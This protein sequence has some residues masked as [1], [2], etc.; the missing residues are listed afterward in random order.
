M[1]GKAPSWL[2]LQ[3]SFTPPLRGSSSVLQLLWAQI[4]PTSTPFML[5]IVACR[6]VSDRQTWPSSVVSAGF[7]SGRV[8]GLSSSF[9]EASLLRPRARWLQSG[10]FLACRSQSG[11]WEGRRGAL[12]RQAA[13]DGGDLRGRS[14]RWQPCCWEVLLWRCGWRSPADLRGWLDRWCVL[15][16]TWEHKLGSAGH[17]IFYSYKQTTDQNNTVA[18]NLKTA[19]STCVGEDCCSLNQMKCGRA[20]GACQG[21]CLSSGNLPTLKYNR[22]TSHVPEIEPHWEKPWNHFGN[23]WETTWASRTQMWRSPVMS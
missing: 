5:P 17:Y 21:K 1:R 8:Y 9:W 14:P 16:G 22:I 7:T 11:Q 19:V 10:G 15:R 13:G 12:L 18:I 3:P 2:G 4:Y 6:Q 20:R 23:G